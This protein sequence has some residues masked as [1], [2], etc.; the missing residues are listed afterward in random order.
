M[1]ND[2]FLDDGSFK[3]APGFMLED[4]EKIF[5]YK[6]LKML[7]KGGKINDAVIE[8]LLSWCHSGFHVYIGDRITLSDKTGLG[9]LAP[10]HF[11]VGCSLLLLDKAHHLPMC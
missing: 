1:E 2:C 9:N 4:L 7:K 10:V 8:N 3:A 6:M 5:Q 11:I